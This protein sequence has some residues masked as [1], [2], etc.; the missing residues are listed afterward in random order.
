MRPYEQTPLNFIDDLLPSWPLNVQTST[1]WYRIGRW[2]RFFCRIFWKSKLAD[3]EEARLARESAKTPNELPLKAE[4]WSIFPL[5][6]TYAA[7]RLYLI[8]EAFVGL[9][10]LDAS[11]YRTVDWTTF[12]PHL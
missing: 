6:C 12:L 3:V 7:A 8:D 4:F 2:Q 5:A 1:A 9:R 11:A 10:A